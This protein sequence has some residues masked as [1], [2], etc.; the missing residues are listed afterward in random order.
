MSK[1]LVPR[2]PYAGA[3]LSKSSVHDVQAAAEH[4]SK[5]T[6]ITKVTNH[7]IGHIGAH[8]IG[9]MAQLTVG[10]HEIQRRLI[11]AGL[12]SDLYDDA[13][14]KIL[15]VTGQNLIT[16]ANAAQKEIIQEAARLMR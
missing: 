15:Q 7:E 2:S 12:D 13:Q 11:D 1:E 6:E 4:G 16:L 3:G 10:A 9:T 8:S 5:V 14:T